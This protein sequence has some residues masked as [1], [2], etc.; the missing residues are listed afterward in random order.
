MDHRSAENQNEIEGRNGHGYQVEK[1]IA[2]AGQH[3]N[4]KL[5]GI[6]VIR[7]LLGPVFKFFIVMAYTKNGYMT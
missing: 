5:V 3:Q 4:A 2:G 7:H 1:A 6:G